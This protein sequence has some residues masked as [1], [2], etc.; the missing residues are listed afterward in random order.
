MRT[1]A[2]AAAAAIAFTPFSLAFCGVAQSTPRC[3]DQMAQANPAIYAQ[4]LQ[5]EQNQ[6]TCGR[7]AGCGVADAS[8]LPPCKQPGGATGVTIACTSCLNTF[9]DKSPYAPTLNFDCGMPGAPNPSSSGDQ[10]HCMVGEIHT[11]Q[12]GCFGNLQADGTV[13]ATD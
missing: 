12:P 9:G 7:A 3:S 11:N 2:A 4:C 10:P 5:A 8:N 13:I 6:N 1:M